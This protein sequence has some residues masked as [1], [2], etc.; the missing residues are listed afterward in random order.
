MLYPVENEK[1][2]RCYFYVMCLRDIVNSKKYKCITSK[3]SRMQITGV[4]TEL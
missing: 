3:A 4:K 2:G 1:L